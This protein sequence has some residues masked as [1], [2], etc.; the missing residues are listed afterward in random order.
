MKGKKVIIFILLVIA[1]FST[2]HLIRSEEPNNNTKEMNS[3]FSTRLKDKNV[4]PMTRYKTIREAG[5]SKDQKVL[6]ELNNILKNPNEPRP[7]RVTAARSLA[8]AGDIKF[9]DYIKKIIETT[10]DDNLAYGLASALG[11][12]KHP[13]ALALLADIAQNKKNS[14][15][16]YKAIQ[17]IMKIGDKN[18]VD[19][20]KR[21][22]KKDPDKYNRAKAIMALA[23]IGKEEILPFLNDI[24]E[25]ESD[26]YVR[27]ISDEQIK[28][29]EGK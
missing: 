2:S 11:D 17:S 6:D 27:Y 26:E 24:K 21:L 22:A 10:E 1:T 23:Q 5:D 20:L 13:K 29:L 12:I 18:T 3:N 19:L 15:L 25:N 28:L 8:K 14:T 16:R 7:I 4:D 9:I